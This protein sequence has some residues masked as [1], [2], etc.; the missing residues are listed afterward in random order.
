VSST[1]AF[2]RATMSVV[3]VEL[4]TAS[5]TASNPHL[6]VGEECQMADLDM[7]MGEGTRSLYLKVARSLSEVVAN[8]WKV[9]R[10]REIFPHDIVSA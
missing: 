3:Q 8:T 2:Q 9:H 7:A 4:R 1:E 6:A 5:M 10:L